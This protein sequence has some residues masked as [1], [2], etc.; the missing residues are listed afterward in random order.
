MFS[1]TKLNLIVVKFYLQKCCITLVLFSFFQIFAHKNVKS[2]CLT[3]IT[4]SS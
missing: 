3:P 4:D 2:S 1:E